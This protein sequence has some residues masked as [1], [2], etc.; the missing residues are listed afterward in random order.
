M[1]GG[2]RKGKSGRSLF[3]IP[4]EKKTGHSP[5][6]VSSKMSGRPTN[7]E[8]SNGQHTLHGVLQRA[9]DVGEGS[10][11]EVEP[12]FT[13][14][15]GWGVI[16]QVVAQITRTLPSHLLVVQRI[17]RQQQAVAARGAGLPTAA[18]AVEGG[19]LARRTDESQTCGTMGDA[20]CNNLPDHLPDP[21][22][23]GPIQLPSWFQKMGTVP[24]RSPAHSRPRKGNQPRW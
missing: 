22:M 13:A 3:P 12:P 11:V 20:T 7:N 9:A 14:D 16:A 6:R 18:E 19:L 2:F 8:P 1:I 15:V 17:Q 21:G 24:S 10:G 5:D 4:T 23:H